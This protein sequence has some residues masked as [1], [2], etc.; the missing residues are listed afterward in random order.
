MYVY[1]C[2]I[3]MLHMFAMVFKCFSVVFAS[4]SG[5]CFKCFICLLLYVATVTSECFKSR[6]DVAHRMRVGS[7]WRR[8]RHSGR[9]GR[10]PGWHGPT[11]GA[12][13]RDM[14]CAR[15]LHLHNSVQTNV[16]ALARPYSHI[17][18]SQGHYSVFCE[19]D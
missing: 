7:G 18:L 3:W 12:L 8:G 15:L 2:F 10:R 1:E 6:S 14:L 4:V 11:V 19:N 16:R 13:P 17:I 9:R 5:A